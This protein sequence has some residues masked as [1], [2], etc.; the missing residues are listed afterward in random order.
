VSQAARGSAYGH[1][2][3][4]ELSSKSATRRSRDHPPVCSTGSPDRS[5]P[6][7]YAQ[8]L[9]RPRRR[10]AGDASFA[11]TPPASAKRPCSPWHDQ[12]V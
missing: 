9:T 7:N 3:G 10:A 8:P 11:A 5:Y 12:A 2:L 6:S 4:V 1:R